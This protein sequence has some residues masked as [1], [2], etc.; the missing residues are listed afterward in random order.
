MGAN[1]GAADEKPAHLVRISRPFYL[2]TT[3]VTQGQWRALMGT[4]P[5]RF[6]LCGADCPVEWVSWWDAVAYCNALSTQEGLPAC[7]KPSGCRGQPG[8]GTYK[9]SSAKSVGSSCRGYRLPTEAEWEY[10]AR[11]GT[12]SARYG[13]VADIAWHAGNSGKT[14]H[15]VARKRANKWGLHDMLGNVYE[16]TSDRY[17]AYGSAATAAPA[18]S[19]RSRGRMARGGSWGL[20][21]KDVRAPLRNWYLPGWRHS[22]LGFRPARLADP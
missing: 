9:C 22:F 13:D 7:Y 16:W 3:E 6:S 14:T 5:S 20:D 17:S 15:R 18:D 1:D 8:D 10:A 2:Q 21:A 12:T 4:S 11:G 19:D